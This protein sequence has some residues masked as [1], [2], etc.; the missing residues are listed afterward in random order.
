MSG[1]LVLFGW[2][3]FVSNTL[4]ALAS[5]TCA[6]SGEWKSSFIMMLQSPLPIQ[7]Q[8]HTT[9][10]S[11]NKIYLTTYRSTD[12]Y[13]GTQINIPLPQLPTPLLLLSLLLLLLPSNTAMPAA[14]ITTAPAA[15]NTTNPSATTTTT[16]VAATSTT[17]DAAAVVVVDDDDD[18]DDGVYR[19]CRYQAPSSSS[20]SSFSFSSSSPILLLLLLPSTRPKKADY[21]MEHLE[22]VSCTRWHLRVRTGWQFLWN[23]CKSFSWI[24]SQPLYTARWQMLIL[25]QLDMD[26]IVDVYIYYITPC[27]WNDTLSYKSVNCALCALWRF[28]L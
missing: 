2:R 1:T 9:I 7:G 3:S 12:C 15:T 22:P 11:A 20:S 21:L 17:P 14:T 24:C 27:R 8:Q 6:I 5:F 4:W 23:V 19:C 16:P 10:W 25:T 26:I 18:D 13:I 28:S